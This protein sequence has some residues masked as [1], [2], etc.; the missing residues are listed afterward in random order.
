MFKR[1]YEWTLTLAG[2]PGATWAL[3][4]ISFA[5]SSFFPLPPDVILVPMS[6]SRPDRAWFYAGLC[7]VTSVLG[8]LVG[9]GIGALLYDSIGH[10][11]ISAYGYGEGM[12]QF[13]KAYAE[14]GAWIILLKGV[15][16]I[17]YKLVTITSG[18]AGYDLLWFT[19]LSLVT[20]GA[21][22]YL[23]AGL[24]NRFGGPIRGLMER[25]FGLAMGLL[26]AIIV[27]GFVLVK[28]VV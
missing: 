21:R 15:T 3:A 28:F 10:W 11:L 20:R 23:L 8:G 18:F 16:P 24:L 25:H 12:E 27:G 19:G 22:F 6:L 1:L 4:A 13:R 7:T 9:Y 17:P 5:E 26:A 2:R 14:Y